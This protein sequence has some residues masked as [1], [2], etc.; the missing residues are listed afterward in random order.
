[1]SKYMYNIFFKYQKQNLNVKCNDFDSL[2]IKVEKKSGV[3]LSDHHLE[4]YNKERDEWIGI[5][6]NDDLENVTEHTEVRLI[7]K[8]KGKNI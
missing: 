6:D 1:M 2:K 3:S 4:Y 7:A 5:S 8:D